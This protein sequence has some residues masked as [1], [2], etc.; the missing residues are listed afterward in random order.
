MQD[1]KESKDWPVKVIVAVSLL[2][3]A[4]GVVLK[5]IGSKTGIKLN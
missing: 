1:V 2:K 3:I 4:L 5:M